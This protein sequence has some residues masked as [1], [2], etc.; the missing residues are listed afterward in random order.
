VGRLPIRRWTLASKRQDRGR[1]RP[2]R[3]R[4]RFRPPGGLPGGCSPPRVRSGALGY[5]PGRPAAVP[6][7]MAA[8]TATGLLGVPAPFPF[9]GSFPGG[10]VRSQ[11]AR[12]CRFLRAAQEEHKG[13]RNLVKA[14]AGRAGGCSSRAI[15]DRAE[16]GKPM[17]RATTFSGGP[18]V[19]AKGAGT[20]CIA[21]PTGVSG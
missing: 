1:G 18:H 12:P 19:R 5:R 15:R 21:R 17:A 3:P 11:A 16:E 7:S 8:P 2:V 9:S 14:A 20:T 6:F 4:G 13:C 10:P